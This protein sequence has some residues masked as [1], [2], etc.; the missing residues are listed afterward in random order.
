MHTD[1]KN[2]KAEKKILSSIILDRMLSIYLWCSSIDTEEYNLLT[3]GACVTTGAAVVVVVGSRSDNKI[4]LKNI[5]LTFQV[6][7]KNIFTWTKFMLWWT[8]LTY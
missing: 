4:Y 5:S 3:E 6:I 8:I 7:L 1:L 2:E